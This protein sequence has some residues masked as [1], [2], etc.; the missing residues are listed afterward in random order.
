[1]HYHREHSKPLMQQLKKMCED[2]IASKRVEPSSRLWEPLTYVLNQW[3]RLTRFC[4]A[5]GVPLDTNLV[6]QALIM[7]VRYFSGSFN[8][9]TE[10]GAVVGDHAM[11]LIATAR[12]SGVEPVAYLTECLRC[13]E[14][15][16]KRPEHYLPWVY[17]ERHRNSNAADTSPRAPP[18]ETPRPEPARGA[19]STRRLPDLAPELRKA[20]ARGVAAPDQHL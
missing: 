17:R 13:H 12:A 3:E 1:M 18:P 16:A 4:D 19:P 9:H 20:A 7:P 2:K 8:Y 5:P 14:D 6:E 10:D 15:L 11:S